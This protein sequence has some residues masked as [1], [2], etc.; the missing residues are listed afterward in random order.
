MD[1]REKDQKWFTLFYL[2]LLS[3]VTCRLLFRAAESGSGVFLLCNTNTQK[4]GFSQDS[5]MKF[6]CFHAE[7]ST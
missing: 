5:I 1:E 2:Y 7:L 3:G 4:G 6:W